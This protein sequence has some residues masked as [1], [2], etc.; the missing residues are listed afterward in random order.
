MTRPLALLLCAAAFLVATSALVACGGDDDEP[1]DSG[2]AESAEQADGGGTGSGDDSSAPARGGGCKDVAAP[3]PKPDGGAKKPGGSLDAGRTYLVTM[4]TSCGDLT[5]RLDQRTAPKTAASFAALV[6]SG[7]YDGTIFHRLVPG[8]VVQGGDPTGTG[9]GGPGYSVRDKPPGDAA[10]TRG[11]VAMAKTAAEPPGTS[12]SQFYIVTAP[13]AGLPPEYAL[14]GKVTKGLS[15]ARRIEQL[16][17][18]A[19][20]EAGTPLRPVVLEKATLR[21]S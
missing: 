21:E 5:I 6:R 3:E 19:S 13:D 2:S 18:P 16:G 10:Y 15:T 14:L 8:F 17:D 7:F 12:G 4:T 9:T 20:G 1:A 11:V